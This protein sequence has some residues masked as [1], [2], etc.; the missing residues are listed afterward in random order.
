[1]HPTLSQMDNQPARE[2]IGIYMFRA[3]DIPHS[4]GAQ[5]PIPKFPAAKKI[6]KLS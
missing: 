6:N 5:C 3:T 4:R 2:S 1:M